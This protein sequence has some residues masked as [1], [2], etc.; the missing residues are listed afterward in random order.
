MITSRCHPSTTRPGFITTRDSIGD[1][2]PLPSS[3][4]DKV[5]RQRR[6]QTRTTRDSA[7]VRS[8]DSQ[9]DKAVD[10][11]AASGAG[12]DCNCE[13]CNRRNAVRDEAIESESTETTDSLA[14]LNNRNRAHHGQPQLRRKA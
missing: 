12:H 8:P 14:S 13:F 7:T 11:T 9:I 4:T 3:G 10:L 2:H 1:Y 5:S 6:L